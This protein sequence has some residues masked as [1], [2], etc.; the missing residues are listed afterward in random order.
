MN[1][2]RG[3]DDRATRL[4]FMQIDDDSKKLLKDFW[5]SVE[6]ALPSLLEGFYRHVTSVPELGKLLGNEVPRLKKAQGSH[7]ERLFSGRFDEAYFQGVRAIGLV[8]NKIGLE[9]RWYIGGYNFVLSALTDLAA[10]TH[11]WSPSKARAIIRAVNCAVMLDMDI[12]ISVYQDALLTERAQRGKR[13][14]ALIGVFEKGATGALALLAS[15]A[16]EM[17][18]TATSLAD[19]AAETMRQATGVAAASEQAS[20]NVQT[21]A[22]ATEEL[23]SSVNEISRQVAQSAKIAAQAVTDADATTTAMRGLADI[24]RNVDTVVKIISEIAG[25]TNL[26][27]LNATIEAAR[28][29]D[30]GKGFA[31][32]ASEVK[33][34][35]N[36]TA[37]ATEEISQQ[38]DAI[39]TATGASVERIDAI[40]TTINEMSR[41]AGAIAAA[42]EQQGAATQEIAR[43]VQEAAAGTGQVSANINVVSQAANETGTAASQV[44]AASGKVAQQGQALQREVDRFLEGI[45]AA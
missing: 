41:I 17:N 43:N 27:A 35:A 39:Q 34:L 22:A 6:P 24:A 45:R 12:A 36:R 19:T 33:A 5:N 40:S 8:H 32:V 14:D 11:R 37:K 44:Q 3:S 7:W 16:T 29:G 9:P 28:A 30:A 1:I 2:E 15:S 13:V 10:K 25:Q 18:A 4:A 31:V 26:L 42:V 38:I 23:S 21:V 20:T